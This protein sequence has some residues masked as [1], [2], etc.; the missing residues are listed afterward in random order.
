[1]LM[2]PFLSCKKA[3]EENAYS[4][5]IGKD[6]FSNIAEA[7]AATLGIYEIMASSNSYTYYVPLVLSV[8]D[9]LGQI[10][11]IS[12]TVNENIMISHYGIVTT[13]NPINNL[14]RAYWR[15]I[16]RANVAI[17]A[18]Q[19]MTLYASGSEVDKTELNRFIGEA[20][21]LRGFYYSELV[22]LW[23]DVPL[24]LTPSRYDEDLNL[25]KTDRYLV[26][27]Q[28]FKDMEEAAELLPVTLP[29]DERVSKWAAK[30][31]LARVAV[32]AGGYSLQGEG[33]A[34]V[35]KRANNYKE[36]YTLAKKQIDDVMT[37]QQYK[38][39]SDY[40]QVFKNQCQGIY[41][42]TENIFEVAF[43]NPSNGITPIGY[44]NSPKVEE[45]VYYAATGVFKAFPIFRNTFDERDLRRDF[46]I[47]TYT[48]DKNGVR[49]PIPPGSDQ[50]Y[51]YGKWSREYQ[52]KN[53]AERT[54]TNI[55]YVI[56]R[57]SDLLLLRAEVENELNEG[58]NFEAYEAIN[59]VRRRGFGIS[60]NNSDILCN[61]LK[62]TASTLGSGYLAEPQIKLSGGGGSGATIKATIA[63]GTN[64]RALTGIFV[65]NRGTGYATLP[66]V[67][68]EAPWEVAQP[69]PVNA[70]QPNVAYTVGT[71]VFNNNNYYNVTAAGTSTAVG[72]TNTSGAS[73]AATTGAV[74]TFL[75]ARATVTI[76]IISKPTNVDLAGLDKTRF[77]EALK[78]ERAWELCFEGLRKY[79][80]NRWN[81]LGA[82]L[83]KTQED[84]IAYRAGFSTIYAAGTNFVPLRHELLPIPISEMDINKKMVQNPGY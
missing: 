17:E 2:T 58:P 29:T 69:T 46:N 66:S 24:R 18:I 53:T 40:T 74:F 36:Y 47:A 38:L 6:F 68:I 35:M 62:I 50:G 65:T 26:Y 70:W 7:R 84:L 32:Y 73:P 41:E 16:D 57:Y 67:T 14:W 61:G 21:F 34:G 55:N 64:L 5:F 77:F 19:K 44:T 3:L 42:F 80:L 37:W 11:G 45:G 54:N 56:M 33:N 49:I 52:T 63:T 27:A 71:K 1:M 81:I 4:T 51:T 20:K 28:I 76:G 15:G 59:I 22:R 43:F 75:G 83:V 13:S 30:A 31:M 72:P 48:I 12:T 60:G 8:D 23:G 10:D 78:Q 82:S 9:D 39:N 79:D 25:P